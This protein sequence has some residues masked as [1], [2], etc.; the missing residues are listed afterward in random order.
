[1]EFRV[2]E[3][4]EY[5]HIARLSWD[6]WNLEHVTK[7]G[8]TVD[9]VEEVLSG[10]PEFRESYKG[11]LLAVGPTRSGSLVAVAIGPDP[12]EP[13]VYYPFSARPISN[14]DRRWYQGRK[15]GE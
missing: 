4:H 3:S 15:V 13:H 11:R 12:I 14:Q 2:L 7:H 8:I 5:P 6:D 9:E 10:S 1:M